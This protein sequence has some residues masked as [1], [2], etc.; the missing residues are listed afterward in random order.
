MERAAEIFKE[1]FKSVFDMV[2]LGNRD[3]PLNRDVL[4]NDPD[5]PIVRT[6]MYL[7]SLEPPFYRVLNR[8]CREKDVSK[9][10]LVGPFAAALGEIVRFQE[11]NRPDCWKENF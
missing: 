6:I 4:R 5:N 3:K 10:E 8:A 11:S 2:E 1:S 7:Y 9:I